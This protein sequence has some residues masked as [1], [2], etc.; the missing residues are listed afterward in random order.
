[1]AGMTSRQTQSRLVD[2][3]FFSLGSLYLIGITAVLVYVISKMINYF[4]N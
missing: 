4:Y 3:L 2:L 1:M